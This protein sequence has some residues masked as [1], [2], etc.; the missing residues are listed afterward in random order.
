ME[1]RAYDR[2]KIQ[3]YLQMHLQGKL[4][5]AW[6]GGIPGG[7]GRISETDRAMALD[8]YQHRIWQLKDRLSC[9]VY[10]PHTK[11]LVDE[12]MHKFDIQ[13]DRSSKEYLWI[14]RMVLQTE[15]RYY[16][17]LMQA[18]NAENDEECL[19]QRKVSGRQE[20]TPREGA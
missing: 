1:N 20:K 14:V 7:G 15:I 5:S 3:E 16:T 12:F 17:I 2:D 11:G 13:A 4:E 19:F 6:A 9:Q 10:G 18:L 8:R